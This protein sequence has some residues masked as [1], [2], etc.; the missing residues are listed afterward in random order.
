EKSIERYERGEQLKKR[1]EALLKEAE[2]RIARIALG[3]DGKP[4]GAAPLDPER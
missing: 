1:C 2:M 3:P 4:A